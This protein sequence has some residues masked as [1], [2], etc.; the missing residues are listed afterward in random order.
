MVLSSI[1][2]L[3]RRLMNIWWRVAVR[4][5]VRSMGVDVEQGVTFHGFPLISLAEESRIHIESGAVLTSHSSFTALGVS[6]PCILR[7][8]RPGA[9]IRI[10]GSTGLSGAVLCAANSITIGRE[11][12]IGAD[13]VIA[14][15]DFHPTSAV[16]RRFNN[17]P[18][19]ILSR[20]VVVEDNVFI[21]TRSIILKGVS[22]GRNSIVGAGSVVTRS[23][24]A[25]SIAAGNPAR[26]IGCV[27]GT[28]RK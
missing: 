28:P 9:S 4:H 10:G 11:C 13:V 18:A 14:D 16:N 2:R 24:P 12:L 3:P 19:D 27:P 23:I 5:V 1:W 7:T 22:I 8:L 6:R 17:D 25:D 21:G 20:A 26:V 15:T